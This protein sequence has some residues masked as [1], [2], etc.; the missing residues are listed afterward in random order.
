MEPRAMAKVAQRQ[1]AA[2]PGPATPLEAFDSIRDGLLRVVEGVRYLEELVGS[3]RSA[4]MMSPTFLAALEAIRV[5]E[6]GNVG[7]LA[8]YLYAAVSTGDHERLERLTAVV[9]ALEGKE[10]VAPLGVLPRHPR[11][12]GRILA[13]DIECLRAGGQNA[14]FRARAE[15]SGQP[16]EGL[17]DKYP[18]ES[19]ATRWQVAQWLAMCLRASSIADEEFRE[20]SQNDR[21]KRVYERMPHGGHGKSTD[22]KLA[23]VDEIFSED[24]EKTAIA[25]FKAA[26]YPADLADQLFSARKMA[27]SRETKK[28]Q[29]ATRASGNKRRM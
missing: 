3:F 27:R 17:G 12:A 28:R 25:A 20:A 7:Q 1:E 11:A 14:L 5:D 23:F 9:R 18:D 16:A 22:R 24:A 29:K 15:A 26:G 8:Q 6:L 13:S 10:I 4:G 21:A 19:P 2:V